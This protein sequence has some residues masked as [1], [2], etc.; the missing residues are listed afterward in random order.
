MKS[1]RY[2]C[3]ISIKVVD[4]FKKKYSNDIVGRVA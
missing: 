4:K 2:S 1:T 3:K